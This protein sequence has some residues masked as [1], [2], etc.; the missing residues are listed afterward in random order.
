MA[1]DLPYSETGLAHELDELKDTQVY[2]WLRHQLGI[3]TGQSLTC[4]DEVQLRW[5]QGQA[6][7]LT[8]LIS[9]IDEASAKAW[10]A[11]ETLR[12]REETRRQHQKQY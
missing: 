1:S 8:T 12:K 9:T 4:K 2:R 5:L 11:R 3:T 7:Q 6:Q 10:D